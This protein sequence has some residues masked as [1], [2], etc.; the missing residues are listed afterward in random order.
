MKH[1]LLRA[2]RD[3]REK[4][5]EQSV[6]IHGEAQRSWSTPELSDAGGP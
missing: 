6:T 1:A 3:Q 5:Q 2:S 4:Q